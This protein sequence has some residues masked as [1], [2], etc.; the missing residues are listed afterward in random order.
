MCKYWLS[1]NPTQSSS[2]SS[3]HNV[4]LTKL[5]LSSKLLLLPLFFGVGGGGNLSNQLLLLRA[6]VSHSTNSILVKKAEGKDERKTV[7]MFLA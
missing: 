7:T 4:D 5:I 6:Q 3:V 2:Y 1:C